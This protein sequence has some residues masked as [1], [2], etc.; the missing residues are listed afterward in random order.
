MIRKISNLLQSWY[1]EQTADEAAEVELRA[2]RLEL[3][4]TEAK[5]E[6]NKLN[7][8]ASLSKLAMYKG[9]VARLAARP[10]DNFQVWRKRP[11]EDAE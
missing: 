1:P 10:T 6:E 2:A 11:A 9:R 8:E 7:L 4:A 3:L 5:V